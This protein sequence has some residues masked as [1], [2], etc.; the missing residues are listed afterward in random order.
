MKSTYFPALT[1]IRA[2]AAFMVFIHHYNPF[3][4]A[5]FGEATF[6]FFSEFHVGV[7]V[8]FVLS[9]FL[10][11]HRYFE[12]DKI[13]FR[14]YLINRF[15]RIYPM[16]FIITTITFL[17][18]IIHHLDLNIKFLGL[19][20]LNIS[21]LKGYFDEFKFSGIAQGWSLTVEEFFY[22]AAPVF[23][24]FI[25]KSKIFLLILPL[26][27]LLFGFYL[28]FL[29]G[30]LNFYGFMKNDGFMLDYTFFGRVMEF[31]TGIALSLI[32]QK[33]HSFNTKYITFF[34][35]M[36]I[37]ISIYCLSVLKV[38]NGFGTDCILG[39]IINTF[40]LPLFGIAPLFF[41]L[42][43]EKTI[44]SKVLESRLFV[45]LGKSS[46]IFYLIH[47]GVF[48]IA[49]K[50]VSDNTVFLFLMLNIISI[51]LYK[52]IETPINSFIRKKANNHTIAILNK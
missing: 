7:T 5:V 44:V 10:I 48:A 39:K 36:A 28:V 45:L 15:A 34:G 51:V 30:D 37:M 22:F 20:I 21:F 2:I 23:F 29:F 25:K 49:F 50:K 6:D 9:G 43:Y 8:F 3:N 46:Y 26:L 16:Y 13:N 35:I 52:Y 41:G 33:S 31:F 27:I 1:G 12:F 18:Y 47:M 19:Y 17:L 38:G 32:V 4:K 14:Q 42:I 24:I 40:L 11:T